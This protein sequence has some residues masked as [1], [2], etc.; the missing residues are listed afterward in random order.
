VIC[1]SAQVCALDLV[2]AAQEFL[3][4]HNATAEEKHPEPISLWDEMQQVIPRRPQDL[5]AIVT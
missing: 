3:Q 1:S 2:L 5:Y 4:K